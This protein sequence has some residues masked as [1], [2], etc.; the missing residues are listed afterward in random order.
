[1]TYAPEKVDESMD[2]GRGTGVVE[3][4][5]PV[6][7]LVVILPKHNTYQYVIS[8]KV[9]Q[10]S[11]LT[12]R[13]QKAKARRGELAHRRDAA[14]FGELNVV[15]ARLG[16]LVWLKQYEE[17]RGGV[18]PQLVPCGTQ[19]EDQAFLLHVTHQTTYLQP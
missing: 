9:K 8:E 10:S 4:A 14:P 3:S 11:V 12:C 7:R 17:K 18:W 5:T 16:H 19:F 15:A 2:T 6:A 1:M 13:S